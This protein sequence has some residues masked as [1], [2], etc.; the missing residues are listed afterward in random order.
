MPLTQDE[1]N[2]EEEIL[3]GKAIGLWIR[4]GLASKGWNITQLSQKIAAMPNPKGKSQS[5]L[6]ILAN[7]DGISTTTQKYHQASEIVIHNIAEALE[8]D[9]NA[10]RL[11]GG[12]KVLPLRKTTRKPAQTLKMPDGGR[13]FVFTPSGNPVEITEEV[14]HLIEVEMEF[15]KTR[16][17][18]SR[19]QS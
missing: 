16:T 9:E 15:L 4:N 13:A 3:R 17:H 7:N 8:I 6:G 5:Y 14:R 18:K 10:G 11:A 1:V 19:K 12:Y 2:T